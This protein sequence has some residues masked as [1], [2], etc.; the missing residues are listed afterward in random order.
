M[1]DPTPEPDPLFHETDPRIRIQIKMKRIHI[2]V[3]F[4]TFLILLIFT[5][6]PFEKYT[7]RFANI[8]VQAC[9]LMIMLLNVYMSRYDQWEVSSCS[10]AHVPAA[11][12]KLWLR[13]LYIP[14]IP[15]T[16]LRVKETS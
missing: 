9:L 1:S 11:L 14:L 2:T 4:F 16:R 6:V 5:L 10:D 15:G 13:E 8:W 12:L 7:G 3:I